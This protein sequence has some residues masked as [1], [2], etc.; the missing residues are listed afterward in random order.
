MA[1]IIDLSTR[2][3][4]AGPT[5]SGE[6]PESRDS[7]VPPMPAPPEATALTRAQ[8][9]AR[10]LYLRLRASRKDEKEALAALQIVLAQHRDRLP[11]EAPP[12]D[13]LLLR[14]WA[15]E[16][17]WE[18]AFT[19]Q[20]AIRS[21][22]DEERRADASL[23]EARIYYGKAKDRLDWHLANERALDE[24]G[25][26]IFNTLSSQVLRWGEAVAK[27]EDH[28]RKLLLERQSEAAQCRTEELYGQYLEQ[29]GGLGP[30]YE[31]LCRQA[32]LLTC[33]MEQANSSGRI[34]P[35]E[36][37]TKLQD[38]FIKVIGQLQKYT[39]VSKSESLSKEGVEMVKAAL[40]VCEDIVAP[41][42]PS[43]WAEIVHA[44]AARLG[45]AAQEARQREIAG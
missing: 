10:A 2:R 17:A 26:K 35:P 5:P 38:T 27:A 4:Q 41:R 30:Q 14:G 24:A 3:G 18:K 20:Q 40:R 8:Q 19:A 33:R 42:Y 28:L 22:G 45:A 37:L 23:Q 31:H 44:V 32:A 21:L 9:I 7:A 36:E 34:V 16:F 25:T 12:G 11:E 43:L 39:E 13:P 1:D 6:S 29:Y 15:D